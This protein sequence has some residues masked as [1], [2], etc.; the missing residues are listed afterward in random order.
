MVNQNNVKVFGLGLALLLAVWAALHLW[1][2][3]LGPIPT[4]LIFGMILVVIEKSLSWPWLY[5][6]IYFTLVLTTF[7]GLK[8]YP[9]SE[10]IVFSNTLSA[11][12]VWIVVLK[13][14][15]L[16]P[17]YK[18]WMKG[19]H[20]IGQAVTTIILTTVYFLVFTPVSFLLRLMGKDHMQRKI[21]VSSPSYWDKKEQEPFSKQRYHQQF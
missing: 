7:F 5:A 3:H 14:E 13:I 15:L 9:I 10:G 8:R 17:F 20:F 18:V 6:G 12:L 4:F 1:Q 2:L 16:T 19:A 21:D 11:V